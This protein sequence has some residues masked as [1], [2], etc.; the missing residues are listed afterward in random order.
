MT[1]EDKILQHFTDSFSLENP[2]NEP[3]SFKV[4]PSCIHLIIFNTKFFYKNTCIT[5]TGISDSRRLPAVSLKSHL[6]APPKI[7]IYRN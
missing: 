3:I 6:K 7:K 2:L 5:V 4:I 1:S